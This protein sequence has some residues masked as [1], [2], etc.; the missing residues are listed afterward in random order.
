MVYLFFE[1]TGLYNCLYNYA[2]KILHIKISNL[3]GT[4]LSMH[5]VMVNSGGYIRSFNKILILKG[6]TQVEQGMV[7][8]IAFNEKLL[9]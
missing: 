7:I 3:H 2:C 4:M 1:A 9:L 6:R 8:L 5:Q